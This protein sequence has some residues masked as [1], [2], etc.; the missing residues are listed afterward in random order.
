MED[1][2]GREEEEEE[3]EVGTVSTELVIH[4]FTSL[5]FYLD[6][7]PFCPLLFFLFSLL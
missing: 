3:E 5:R 1:G 2:R 6:K 4:R 7:L